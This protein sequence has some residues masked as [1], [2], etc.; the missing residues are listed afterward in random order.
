MNYNII[1]A[2]ILVLL[3]A[4]LAGKATK[5]DNPVKTVDSVDLSRYLGVWYQQAFFPARFQKADCGK[6]V[7]AEYSLDKKGKINVTNTCYS[8]SEGK[9]IRKQA[10]AKAWT[11]DPSNSKLKVM[12]FWHFKGDYWI[13][14]LD[15]KN[16]SYTV[17]SDPNREYLWILSRSKIMDKKTFDE[18]VN[19]LGTNGWDLSR[20][21]V[22]APIK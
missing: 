21:V 14:K 15:Q 18:I 10:K 17:V 19:F 3:S 7:T 16:Y 4:G 11:V 12:F 8:D 2:L 20:L 5:T 6:V 13:V 1:I 22:T 9:V